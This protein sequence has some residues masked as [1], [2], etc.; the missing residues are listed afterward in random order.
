MAHPVDV[1]ITDLD[2]DDDDVLSPVSDLDANV[3]REEF[4]NDHDN[5]DGDNN[6]FSFPRDSFFSRIKDSFTRV[7]YRSEYYS[8]V[9]KSIA[10]NGIELTERRFN[11]DIDSFDL[12]DDEFILKRQSDVLFKALLQKIKSYSL[13]M[14]L[15][16]LLVVVI[17]LSVLI[18][19]RPSGDSSRS[20]PSIK[21][22]V[23]SNG[24]ASF[25]P[26]TILISLDGFHPHYISQ[27]LTPSLHK[28][29]TNGHGPPYMKPSFPSS[30]FPNHW[31]IATGLYP[32][33]H[34][35]VGNTFFDDK[36]GRQFIN[37]IPEKSLDPIFWGGEPI[38]STAEFNGVRSAIHMF[39]GSEVKFPSG[40]PTEVDKF[41]GTELL[42][43]KSKRILEW[44]DRDITERPE[45]IIGYVPTIDSIGH[46]HGIKGK[47]IEAGLKYVDSFIHNI[48]SS[49][50]DRNLT[51]IVN[52]V[53]VSDHGMS[54]TS[55]KRLVYLDELVNTT[56]IQ[57]VDGWPLFGLRPYKEYSVEEVYDELISNF[58]ENSGYN[59]YLKEN[60]PKEFQF[61]GKLSKSNEK[62]YHRIAPIWVIPDVGYSITTHD[63]MERKNGV[64]SPKGV[65]GYNNSEVLMRAIFLGQGPYFKARAT[66]TEKDKVFKIKPFQNIE[67]YNILCETLNIEPADNNGTIDIFSKD[68]LPHDWKD[69]LSYPNVDFDI[70]GILK[71]DA[72]YDTLFRSKIKQTT[73][74]EPETDTTL[75]ITEEAVEEAISS[76]VVEEI[77]SADV[78]TTTD[79]EKERETKTSASTSTSTSA[80]TSTSTSNKQ[81]E[82]TKHEGLWDKIEDF[83]E[84]IEEELNEIKED[85]K[86]QVDD[87]IEDIED[88]L[89]G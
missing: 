76:N 9:P 64:Y 26:T 36:L 88:A 48:T 22:D 23:L 46:K 38:W 37:V 18:S 72:T 59:V 1:P 84:D 14:L 51:D 80:S 44:L 8:R 3:L 89:D 79:K 13:Y 17:V 41:N 33:S 63:D 56:K 31:S 30:T 16:A 10:T 28:L 74:L 70:G 11:D 71:F 58:K 53:V 47:A 65:H 45:L 68:H 5:G 55:E 40:N 42:E 75:S 15:L 2:A 60:L 78:T 77:K 4:D 61:G 69:P 25:Y 57:Q 82:P 20:R 73:T 24:T 12:S 85:I 21:K 62:Y 6:G 87:W 19:K 32:E 39:P 7:L 54:P 86:E 29:F 52:F 67:V 49:L 66:A 81:S 43:V 35:I 34:G 83:A 27:E 50:A